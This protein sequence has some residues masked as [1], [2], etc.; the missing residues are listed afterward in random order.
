ML[1]TS[2]GDG[3]LHRNRARTAWAV[4]VGELRYTKLRGPSH[5]MRTGLSHLALLS[6]RLFDRVPACPYWFQRF[7][8]YC[9]RPA[10]TRNQNLR[11]T[12]A[13]RPD[14]E[15]VGPG[16]TPPDRNSKPEGF[17][18]GSRQPHH[19][20]RGTLNCSPNLGPG[21]AHRTQL[22]KPSVP[23]HVPTVL[24]P[25]QSQ[26]QMRNPNSMCVRI[27]CYMQF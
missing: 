15:P 3:T 5:Q 22:D 25:N 10:H 23:T 11:K 26:P 18:Q 12:T 13:P 16:R 6:A 27:G 14:V 7:T 17:Y 2:S 4:F 9:D 21:S 8:Q 19:F 1:P 20:V 24:Q